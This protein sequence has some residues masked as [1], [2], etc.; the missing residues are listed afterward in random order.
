MPGPLAQTFQLLGSTSNPLA[1]E[2]LIAA[3]DVP[4][5]GIQGEATRSIVSRGGVREQMEAIRRYPQFGAEIRQQLEASTNSLT[6]AIRQCLV[7]GR[8]DLE[9]AALDLARAGEA[10][11]IIESL[12]DVLQG[13]RQDLQ[14]EAVGALRHLVN[15]LYELLHGHRDVEKSPLKNAGQIQHLAVMALDQALAHFHD[16]AH[17]DAVVE[18]LLALGGPGHAAA[19]KL[20]AQGNMECRALA[21][22][23]LFRSKHPGVMRFSLES[24]ARP[25]PPPRVIDALEKRDDPEFMLAT[26]RWV[27]KRWTNT[28]ERN[29][30][31]IENIAWLEGGTEALELVPE[32]LQAALVT[33]TSATGLCR[34]DK[35]KVR[36]WVVRNG[37]P[38]ARSAA[39]AVLDELDTETVQEIVLDGLE[40][41]NPDV[42]AWATGQLRSQHVPDAL[43]KL[44]ERLDSPEACVQAVA[45]QELQG[46]D[47]ECLLGRFESMAPL[48]RENAGR[49]LQKIDPDCLLKL[50][51]EFHHPIRR[52][53]LRALRGSLAYGWHINILPALLGILQD[54]DALIRRTAIEVLGHIPAPESIASLVAL[55]NDPSERVRE[56][57]EQAL[58]NLAS[59]EKINSPQKSQRT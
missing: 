41:E 52:R 19:Q 10:F 37:C 49:L 26:L 23:L 51:Q 3:L 27:P 6:A 7:L 14:E 43:N 59:M 31:Q 47:L 44:I 53:R 56:T 50:T 4:W 38:E 11:G 1:G 54:E 29:L 22:E 17:A 15:R 58:A 42:Q 45:R 55:K 25:Y 2:L 12:L 39:V 32:D 40:S 48:A 24:L 9:F 21:R 8:G 18:S 46:F 33:Y 16:L 34:E 35:L 28:Q 20:L 13:G 30:K 57:V 36:Q 5:A